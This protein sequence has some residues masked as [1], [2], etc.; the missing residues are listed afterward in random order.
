MTPDQIRASVAR[1]DTTSWS[2]QEEIWTEL[3]PCGEAVVPYLREAYP[4]FR[5]W[6]GRVALVYRSIR[7]ARVSEDAFQLGLAALADRATLV[8][9]RACSL[10]AYSL[11]DDA[12]GSLEA[13]LDHPDAETVADARAALDA[14]RNRNHHYFVDRRHSGRTFWEVNTGDR[15]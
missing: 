5:K 14:I 11:R 4:R 2:D 3:R 12:I 9:Y 1:L 10:L 15:E 13:L 8:R 7:Y 6:Q